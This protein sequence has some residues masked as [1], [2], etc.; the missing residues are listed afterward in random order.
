MVR[1]Y[2]SRILLL[3]LICCLLCAAVGCKPK[4]DSDGKMI[5]HYNESNGIQTLDPAYASGQAVIW[6]CNLLYNGLVDLDESLN[7]V[8]AIAKRWTISDDGCVYTFYLR[9]DVIFHNTDFYPFKQKRYVTAN[10]FV[11]SLSRIVDPEVASPGAWIFQKVLRDANGKPAFV[12]FLARTSETIPWAQA[13]SNS[14]YGKR[15]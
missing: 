5:F 14:N 12:A 8:P 15:A 1:L 13:L 11:Y 7:I 9:D 10:D 2:P 6:P 3:G 4:Y